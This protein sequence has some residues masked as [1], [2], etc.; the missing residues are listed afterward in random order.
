[1]RPRSKIKLRTLCALSLCGKKEFC[2]KVLHVLDHSVPLFSG[3]SFRSQSIIRFQQ[4]L[5]LEP[6]VLTSPKH[7]SLNDEVEAR[8]GIP[9]SRTGR[10]RD[11]LAARLAVAS[12]LGLML[13]L[14]R[15]I[16]YVVQSEKIDLIHS[17]SPL[18]N[19]LPALWVGRRRKIPVVYEARAF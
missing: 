10:S 2:V 17:H 3:Y 14:A 6:V 12:E 5:G 8:D 15:R 9:Y 18:L 19:G 16:A 7:G 1:R 11:G 4:A 13:C